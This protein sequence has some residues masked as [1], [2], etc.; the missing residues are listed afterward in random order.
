MTICQLLG[1]RKS[2][3]LED[4]F[5]WKLVFVNI[6]G[7]LLAFPSEQM[8]LGLKKM[9]YNNRQGICFYAGSQGVLS[10]VGCDSKL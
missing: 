3:H 6:L 7:V 10:L 1:Q 5:F 8:F 2:L 4:T 9:G